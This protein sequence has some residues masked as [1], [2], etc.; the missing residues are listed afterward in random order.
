MRRVNPGKTDMLTK[1]KILSWNDK[2]GYGFIEPIGGGK[3][4][5]VHIKAFDNRNRRPGINQI[6]AYALSTDEQGRPC[7]AKATLAEDRLSQKTKKP[8]GT[9]S[10]TSAAIFLLI[11]GVSAITSKIPP[12][13]F[14]IYLVASLITFVVYAM[15]KSAARKGAW[16][17]QESILH[18]LSLLGG[19]PGALVAQQKLRHK[20]KKQSFRAVFWVTVIV[21]CGVFA[22]A[23]TSN[24]AT[25]LRNFIA[26]VA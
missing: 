9:I 3:R 5:F 25:T 2:K 10:I 23:L 16:R 1:G 8:R 24:G 7:A 15:D 4:V 13:V 26:A 12:V 20:S 11:V 17:T 21:N 14:A 18:I 19:W 22:W 6:V